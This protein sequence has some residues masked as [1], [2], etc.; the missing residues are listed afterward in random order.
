MF[1]DEDHEMIVKA[2]KPRKLTALK[3]YFVKSVIPVTA[4]HEVEQ[5]T[6]HVSKV[7]TFPELM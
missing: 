5:H 6:F 7:F 2:L 3:L 4:L 1:T